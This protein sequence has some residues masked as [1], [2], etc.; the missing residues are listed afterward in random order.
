VAT[1]LNSGTSERLREVFIVGLKN[2]HALEHQALSIMTPQVSRI[3]NY[4]EV[5]DRLQEHIEET[6]GQITRLDEILS[7]LGQSSSSLKDAALSMSGGMAA[8]AHS[9]AGD[10][11]LKNS[12]ANYAFENFEIASYK[13]LLT[14]ARDGGF[15][16]F[17]PLLQQILTQEEEMAQWIDERLPMITRRY[18]ELSAA[19]GSFAAKI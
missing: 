9:F 8:I 3:E 17:V 1:S 18:V 11:I 6:N 16:A 19:E 12:F 7:D 13:S 2:A 5:A 15:Q 10:E 4:P 14:L